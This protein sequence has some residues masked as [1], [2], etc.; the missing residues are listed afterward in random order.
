MFRVLQELALIHLPSFTLEHFPLCTSSLSTGN[1][2]PPVVPRIPEASF[3]LCFFPSEATLSGV[4]TLP[5]LVDHSCSPFQSHLRYC[6]LWGALHKPSRTAPIRVDSLLCMHRA[7]TIH[8]VV[9][10]MSSSAGSGYCKGSRGF[11]CSFL[12]P[13]PAPGVG[14]RRCLG[15]T[16]GT[17]KEMFSVVS[18]QLSSV[19]RT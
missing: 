6:P 17:S 18:G 12:S 9:A 11:S 19:V 2:L 1:H 3:Q 15:N 8:V 4:T 10:N 5:L 7:F 14:H 16:L 13:A